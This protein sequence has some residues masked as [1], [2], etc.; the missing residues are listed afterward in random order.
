MSTNERRA[1]V[2]IIGTGFSGLGM[3]IA[4]RRAGMD[5]FVVFERAAAVGGTWRD[6]TY[7]GC[8]C[9]VPS[10]LYSFSF[11]L[12]PDWSRTYSMQPEIYEYLEQCA[13]DSGV[14]AQVR[15]EHRVD[16]ARWDEDDS[17]W[18]IGT[19]KG[20]WR[21]D[22]LVSANGAL[23]EPSIPDI[24]GIPDFDGP[25]VHS[26]AWDH[27]VDFA[28]QKIAV[29]GTGASAIQIIPH[30]QR[31]AQS[32]IVFQRTPAWVM[33][34]TDRKIT[35]AEKKLYRRFP[36]AQRAVRNAIYAGREL[37]VFGMVKD[38]RFLRPLQRIATMHIRTKI[39]DP[40]LR[41]KLIPSYELGC[42]RILLS[43]DYYPA[44][45]A[46][47]CDLVTE[48]IERFTRRGVRTTDGREH[49]V[50][51]VVLA[52]GFKVTDNPVLDGVIGAHGQSLGE[53]WRKEGMQAYLGTAVAEFP[54]MFMLTGPNTGIGHTS[55]L[56][57]IE[58]QINYVLR[59]LRYMDATRV[60]RI[61]VRP[62]AV[63][64]FNRELQRRMKETVWTT[65]G[66]AS[67]YLDR[68]GNNTTLW[69]DFTWKFRRATKTFDPAAYFVAHGDST[70]SSQ[71]AR[72][73]A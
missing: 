57:M 42:K 37:L 61:E 6:N 33:P 2:A 19:S 11:R 43:D 67:W 1:R 38:R 47:N 48:R 41:R 27:D 58:A 46:D 28:G 35:D 7:P 21:A 53:I 14:L 68:R 70:R 52:T 55:L 23:A 56:V 62:E 71:D 5:D 26:A 17:S 60:G 36:L 8:Q 44:L 32:L 16:D 12:N 72:V 34:H 3:A 59:A 73:L 66:C 63:A 49:E 15:F 24:P 45:N 39:D 30:L 54:N 50:D 20:T 40:E 18:I 65:G 29:L 25:V 13:R 4:L 9:D 69:P 51:A 31:E 64:D 10:H 22:I